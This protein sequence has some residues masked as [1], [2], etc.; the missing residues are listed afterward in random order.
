MNEHSNSSPAPIDRILIIGGGTAGWMSATYLRRLTNCQV[1]LIESPNVPTVGVGEAT[2][3]AIV[4][5]LKVLDLNEDEFMRRC[6]ATYKLG[7][8]FIDWLHEDHRYWHPFGLCGGQLDNLDLFHFWLKRKRETQNQEEYAA[9]SLQALLAEAGKVHRT[10]GGNP[11]VQNYAFHLD[12]A[13]FA[14]YLQSIAT[15]HGVRHVSADVQQVETND[16]GWI[17]GV[18]LTDGRMVQADLYLDCTGSRGLLIEQGL[19]DPYV[20]WSET[21][22]CDRAAVVSLPVDPQMPPYTQA[23]AAS[24][25]WIWRIPLQNRVGC[26]YV[27]SN[28]HLSETAAT[29]ELLEF[30]GLPDRAESSVRHL[31]MRVGRRKTF[32]KS[33]CV[34]IGL[35]SGFIEPLE[36]TGIFLVQRAL[37]VLLDCFPDQNCHETLRQLFNDRLEEAYEETRDFVLLHYLLSRRNDSPFWSAARDVPIPTSLADRL[38]RYDETAMILES[39]HPVFREMNFYY[40]YAG[41]QRLPKRHH[42]R[43]NFSNFESVCQLLDRIKTNNHKLVKQ[44]PGHAEF[45]DDLLS[46]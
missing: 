41:N 7:I 33:N 14:N 43:A 31:P 3:P 38:Q 44:M 12:A 30:T 25:G 24:A 40:I 32:W 19:Q 22:L 9:Y 10:I 35:S 26:G 11:I 28:A 46:K 5:F 34:S 4:D 23:T 20:D 1:A 36:S 45:L 27:Y 6:Q 21:L 15:K 8:E 16:N 37:E 18:E 13:A 29:H 42:A 39:A 17:K 2:I